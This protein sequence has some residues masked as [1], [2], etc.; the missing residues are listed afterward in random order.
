MRDPDAQPAIPEGN[1]LLDQAKGSGSP[2]LMKTSTE[3][4]DFEDIV[5]L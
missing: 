1:C 5:L 4:H 3:S 2:S